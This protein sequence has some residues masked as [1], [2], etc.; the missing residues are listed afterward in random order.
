[1]AVHLELLRARIDELSLDPLNPRL[2][3][4][5]TGR[6]VTQDR[7][8]ELMRTWSLE[9][10][11]IS[12]MESGYWPQEALVVHREELYGDEALVVVEGNRRL[13]ALR[14]LKRALDGEPASKRWS[15]IASIGPAPEGLFDSIP[16]LL[17]DDRA[18]LVSFLGFRHV[19]GIKEWSPAEKAEYIGRLI[20]EE[21][22]DYREV[23]RRIGSKVETVRRNYIAYRILLQL[24]DMEDVSISHVEERFSVLFLSLRESGVREF[25]GVDIL[26]E[27]ELAR[28]PVGPPHLDN[29]RDFSVWLFGTPD[30]PPLFSDSRF[31]GTFSRVLESEPAVEYLQ[32]S[33][34]PSF[35]L[36]VRKAGADRPELMRHLA[37]ATDDIEQGLS[38]V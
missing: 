27:P 11:A 38:L 25:L 5:N 8:L 35:D 19:T 2:G 15:E 29:L 18:D 37:S 28:E 20:D 6:D 34:A 26:A 36:A 12:F 4:R 14:L 33:D 31:V 23:A 3:R 32:E 10:L 21:G 7:V 13:G 9:E 30:A 16:H 22:M 24:E 1:M 17:V